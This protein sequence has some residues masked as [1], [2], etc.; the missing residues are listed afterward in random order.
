MHSPFVCLSPNAVVEDDRALAALCGEKEMISFS[1][2]QNQKLWGGGKMEG[3]MEKFPRFLSP[4]KERP[5]Y[6]PAFAWWENTAH[7]HL[8]KVVINDFNSIIIN[9]T[10]VRLWKSLTSIKR[11][12]AP[13][14]KD[15]SFFTITHYNTEIW[16]KEWKSEEREKE[17][18]FSSGKTETD[19]IPLDGATEQLRWMTAEQQRDP[20][21]W[22]WYENNHNKKCIKMKLRQVWTNNK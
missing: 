7:I 2:E 15:G 21:W 18:S 4:E 16:R 19:H 10:Q 17:V 13:P 12:L 8:S 5:Y 1:L 22:W 11:T 9:F 3:K 6:P 20:S 14:V